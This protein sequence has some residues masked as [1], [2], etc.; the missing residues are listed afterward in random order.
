MASENVAVEFRVILPS[1]DVVEQVL[2]LV[3]SYGLD[4]VQ[5]SAR[6]L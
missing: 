4:E 1:H 2:D 5:W 3:E 6:F